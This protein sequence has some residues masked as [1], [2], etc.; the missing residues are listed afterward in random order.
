[1]K[2]LCK[3]EDQENFLQMHGDKTL[4]KDMDF[5]ASKSLST[6]CIVIKVTET[7]IMRESDKGI[8]DL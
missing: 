8:A 2:N 7:G 5:Y 3:S 1:M 6:D 4:R